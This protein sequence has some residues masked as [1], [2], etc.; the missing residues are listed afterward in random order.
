[1]VFMKQRKTTKQKLYCYV[2]ETGQDSGAEFFIVVAVVSDKEQDMLRKQLIKIE[3]LAKIGLRKW[4]KSQHKRK[5]QYLQLILEKRVGKGEIYFGRYKKPIP[6]FL[7]MLETLEKS[8]L[9]KAKKNYQTIIY[10]DGIDKKKAAELTNALRI[11]KI[12]LRFVRSARDESEPLIRLADRWAGCIRAAF[13]GK[14]D[15][16]E[17]F[18]NAKKQKYIKKI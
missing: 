2:D 4:H 1:M 14:K 10:V 13:S 18:R 9:D 8:I 12:K 17:I 16:K 11:R 3:S 6:F 5:K 7:P 15:E